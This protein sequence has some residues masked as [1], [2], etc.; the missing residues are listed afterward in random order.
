MAD[1][2]VNEGARG[3][4]SYAQPATSPTYIGR[5]DT[6]FAETIALQEKWSNPLTL[7]T[8]TLQRS[9]SRT[10][11]V[12][13]WEDQYVPY[14]DQINWGTNY[15]TS[16]TSFTVDHG[17]YFEVGDVV[18]VVD[19]EEILLIT[20]KS[21]DVISGVRDYG[22]AL[23]GATL[24]GTSKNAAINDNYYLMVLGNAFE[25]GHT[26]PTG[27]HTLDVEKMNYCQ[28]FRT[29]VEITEVAAAT[30]LRAEQDQAYQERK[31]AKEHMQGIERA[32]WFGKPS[33]GD[34][35]NYSSTT[36]NT[37]PATCGGIEHY[38]ELG[39]DSDHLVDQDDLTFFEF[40]DWLEVLF[41]KG[42]KE[43]VVYCPPKLRWGLEKWGILKQNTFETT[44][45]L[46]MKVGAWQASCGDVIFVTH[47]LLKAVSSSHYN[48]AFGL[49]MEQLQWV[50]FSNIG[51]TRLRP[52]GSHDTNGKTLTSEEYETIQCIIVKLPN[53]HARLR[54]KTISAS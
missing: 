2:T 23:A 14:L 15:N 13:Y 34:L 37:A 28:D 4:T 24:Y 21:G 25:P 18:Q 41:D 7:M 30:Q 39:C 43:K 31:S 26:L 9:R 42:S 29:P 8:M 32:N 33:P 10:V 36:G 48:K 5:E 47:D 35:G 11:D 38:L 12:H 49:D 22:Y 3:R 20:A 50:T 16:A 51:S 6:Q 45:K 53:N 17:E 44:T 40:M 46:G 19:T 1:P 54:F 52:A 27:R